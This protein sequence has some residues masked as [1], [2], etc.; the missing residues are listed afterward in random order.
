M[1]SAEAT[2]TELS[3]S[4]AVEEGVA[5]RLEPPD[6]MIEGGSKDSNISEDDG[7]LKIDNV[8][9]IGYEKEVVEG[10]E[11]SEV[12]IENGVGSSEAPENNG[13]V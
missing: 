1:A 5:G 8:G 12:M 13:R 11:P 7:R 4:K 9:S 3:D 10:V 2:V 6:G